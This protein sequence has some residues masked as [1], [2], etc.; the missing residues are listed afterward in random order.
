MFDILSPSYLPCSSFVDVTAVRQIINGD[1][2]LKVIHKHREVP[3]REALRDLGGGDGVGGGALRVLVVD[4]GLE[5]AA[6]LVDADLDVEC[7]GG[8]VE[9]VGVG[10]GVMHH[11]LEPELAGGRLQSL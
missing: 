7:L 5:H 1:Q 9:V 10:A 8:D 3:F 6:G 4:P 2:P 11:E